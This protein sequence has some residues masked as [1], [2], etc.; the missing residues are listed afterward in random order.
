MTS[1]IFSLFLAVPIAA[2]AFLVLSICSY[3]SAKKQERQQP[4][5]V[6]PEELKRHKIMLIL[7]AILAGVLLVIVLG[8]FALM[9][10]AV[11]FM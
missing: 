6:S 5:S 4:G 10:M 2:I 1:L 3:T 9:F 7:S 8:F 11:A